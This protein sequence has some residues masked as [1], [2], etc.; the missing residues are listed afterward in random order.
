MPLD[1]STRGMLGLPQLRLMRPDAVLVNTARGGIVVEPDLAT[2][3]QRGLIAYAAVD[4]YEQEPYSGPLRDLPNLTMTAHM[5]AAA[6]E[7]RVDMEV[8]AVEEVL[9]FDRGEALKNRL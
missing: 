5:G 8:Q 4:V 3:L 1:E 9:R 2:A 7:C 6:A